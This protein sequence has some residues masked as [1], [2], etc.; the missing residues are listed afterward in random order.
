M[1]KAYSYTTEQLL[2]CVKTSK[3]VLE[4]QRK[5]GLKSRSSVSLLKNIA[6]H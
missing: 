6:K 2:D 5:L 1:A 4:V 3:S